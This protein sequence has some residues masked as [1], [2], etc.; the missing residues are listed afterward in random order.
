MRPAKL[1]AGVDG[2]RGEQPG[3]LGGIRSLDNMSVYWYDTGVG[4]TVRDWQFVDHGDAA[5]C[6]RANRNDD[7]IILARRED[8]NNI[9]HKLMEIWQARHTF[10][11]LRLS[12]DPSTGKP[13]LSSEQA[14]TVR[15]VIDDDRTEQFDDMW[16]IV[17]GNNPLRRSTLAPGTCYGNVIIPLA[18]SGSPFWQ[19]LIEIVYHETCR[20]Q[21]L[22]NTFLRR[23]FEHLAI[24]P[25]RAT[26]LWRRAINHNHQPRDEA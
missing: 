19:A 9:W 26:G 8:N 13:W 10:D 6:T 24:K 20:T 18:G 7:W 2:F 14:A 25:R 17:T 11:A 23:V 21:F 3:E 1:Y 4:A 15:V 22:M 12:I 5:G 16:K